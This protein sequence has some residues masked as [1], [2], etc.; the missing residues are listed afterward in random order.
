MSYNFLHVWI[1][2]LFFLK[3]GKLNYA[4]VSIML[5]DSLK[6]VGGWENVAVSSCVRSFWIRNTASVENVGM[7]TSVWPGGRAVVRLPLPVPAGI[8]SKGSTHLN[9]RPTFST[10]LELHIPWTD[11]AVPSRAQVRTDMVLYNLYAHFG[12][13]FPNP[14]F[15]DS[16]GLQPY[17]EMSAG[18]QPLFPGYC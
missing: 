1:L 9:P 2:I 8:I 13:F 5:F 7:G 14:T 10:L 3:Y 11:T 18:P 4:I 15:G 17:M 12:F 16:Q 6:F